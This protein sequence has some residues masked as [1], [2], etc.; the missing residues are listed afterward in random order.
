MGALL[1]G[2]LMPCL[3]V[4]IC[5]WHPEMELLGAGDMFDD[6]QTLLSAIR[7]LSLSSRDGGGSQSIANPRS[8]ASRNGDYFAINR[9]MGCSASSGL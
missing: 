9:E 7:N 1:K 4:A 2:S 5:C 6:D 8:V 3:M